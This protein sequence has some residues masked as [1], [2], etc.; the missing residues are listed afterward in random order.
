MFNGMGIQYAGTL[1]G[2]VAVVLIPMPVLFLIYGKRIRRRSKMAPAPDIKLDDKRRA[3]QD[4]ERNAGSGEGGVTTGSGSG[5][6]DGK[7]KGGE[8]L[9]KKASV[10]EDEKAK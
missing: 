6:D 9:E 1:L 7:E 2:C 10:K 5:S 4:V 8:G 3:A